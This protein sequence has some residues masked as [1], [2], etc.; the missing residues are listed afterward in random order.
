MGIFGPRGILWF[1]AFLDST[2]PSLMGHCSPQCRL[3]ALASFVENCSLDDLM[4]GWGIVSYCGFHDFHLGF[5]CNGIGVCFCGQ[6][7]ITL[8]L[9]TSC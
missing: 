3:G 6:R 8:D 1:D 5:I 4:G 9:C 7:P 2:N